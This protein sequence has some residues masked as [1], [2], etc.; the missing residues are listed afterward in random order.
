VGWPFP[1]SP[2]PI[3]HIGEYFEPL[4]LDDNQL[5]ELVQFLVA[6]TT[7]MHLIIGN[8]NNGIGNIQQEK[9][10]EAIV[11]NLSLI[12]IRIMPGHNV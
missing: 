12:R 7:I 8:I 11:R 5:N 1:F 6:N 4:Y 9:I 3:L 2:S 10:I